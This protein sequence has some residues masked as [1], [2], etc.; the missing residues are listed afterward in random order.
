MELYL[1]ELAPWERK[2]EYYSQ[3]Q[4][5]KDVKTQTEIIKKHSKAMIFSQLASTDKLIE[6]QK[7]SNNSILESQAR[8]VTSQ[9]RIASGIDT[10]AYN[11]ESVKEGI[12]GLKAAFEWGIS[13]VIWQIEKNREYLKSILTVLQNP[14]E[15]QS[16]EL[17]KRADEAYEN[18]WIDDA[19]EDYLESEKKNR[20]DFSIHISLGMIFLFH[21]KIKEKALE[22]F[23]KAIKYTKPKSN[24]LTS[25]SL[26]HYALIMR[27]MGRIAEAENSSEQAINLCPDFA[28]AL[29]QNALYNALLQD[30]TKAIPR[31]EKAIKLDLNYCEKIIIESA[32]NNIRD[33]ITGLFR[34]LR[35]E[36]AV[37][38]NNRYKELYNKFNK[39]NTII[40]ENNISNY[41]FIIGNDIKVNLERA[42]LLLKLNSYRDC[43]EANQIL[44]L[45][46][47]GCDG[48][49]LYVKKQI[50]LIINEYEDKITNTKSIIAKENDKYSNLSNKINSIK[51]VQ[52]GKKYEK[53]DDFKE[54]FVTFGFIAGLIT[55]F[56]SLRG[57]Y[58]VGPVKMGGIL[59]A[60]GELFKILFMG[61][62]AIALAYVLGLIFIPFFYLMEPRLEIKRI[63]SKMK[64]LKELLPGK[65]NPLKADIVEWNRVLNE[66]RR[67]IKKLRDEI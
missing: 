26:L 8:I 31:L 56:L 62:G 15:T 21:K 48:V 11:I 53:I 9:E 52:K 43:L 59:E 24:Y 16:K 60:F 49:Y 30:S 18:G 51:Y 27:D 25:F 7:S 5:G 35:D 20:Y 63:K 64:E 47:P 29:Y 37:K 19:I 33:E 3:I 40:K 23:K 28:E 22:Y 2:K 39:I 57:C 65:I 34:K 45:L 4:L 46:L 17:K 42:N 12:L 36:I 50:E 61:A 44:S 10:V 14:L 6:E 13:E 58:I 38:A 54:N 32:F 1:N 55:I 66:L 67:L 41:C